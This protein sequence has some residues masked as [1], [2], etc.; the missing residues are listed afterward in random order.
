MWVGDFSAAVAPQLILR[1]QEDR[2]RKTAF[3]IRG[4]SAFAQ[5]DQSPFILV[6]SGHFSFWQKGVRGR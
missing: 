4:A 1:V 2:L 6:H 5:I 3:P